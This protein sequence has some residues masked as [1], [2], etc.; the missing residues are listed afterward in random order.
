MKKIE[1]SKHKSILLT[2]AALT[3]LLT[4]PAFAADDLD[5]LFRDIS[6]ETRTSTRGQILTPTTGT[7][8]LDKEVSVPDSPFVKLPDIVPLSL[9]YWHNPSGDGEFGSWGE[10]SKYM[11]SVSVINLGTAD[12]DWFYGCFEFKVLETADPVN[13]PVGKK[14]G[15]GS[16]AF[17]NG[18]GVMDVAYATYCYVEGFYI[19]K[20]VTKA[21]VI[22]IADVYFKYL[23]G[24]PEHGNVVEM[25][26]KN[27]VSEPVIVTQEQD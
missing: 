21:E 5:I 11:A 19:P 20:A 6:G 4:C 18:V 27:N 22:F 8:P 26:E 23:G 17:L 10:C 13:W 1:T 25:D 9:E 14:G 16:A 12:A 3:T 24:T 15:I 7:T 2:A